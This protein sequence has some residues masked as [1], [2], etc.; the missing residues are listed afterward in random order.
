MSLTSV[1]L[2][3]NSSE[4]IGWQFHRLA[5][6][7]ALIVGDAFVV[8]VSFVLAYVMRFL[9]NLPFF[10]EGAMQSEFYTLLIMML[11]PSWIALFAVYH[12]YDDK[13][14]FNGTQEYQ[15]ITNATSMGMLIVVLL[16]FFWDNL[17]VARG[18]LLLSWFLSLS[19]MTLWRF[20]VR[21]FVYWL[22][23][24]G[25]LH[26]RVL[27]IGATE[28]GRAIAEQLLAEQ[29]A[30]AT[31]V[32]FIDNTLPVG[33]DVI[34]GKVKVLGTTGDFTELIQHNNI[35]TIIIADTNLIREQ[36]ITI[37]GAMDVLS[38]L[39][40]MLAPGLFDLLTIG[41]QVREQ[42]A[43]PLLSLNKT[44]ITGL[45]A[46]GK[47]IV[48]VV[49]AL[50]GLMLLSPL[51][52]CVAIA[53]KLDSPGPIIYRRRVIGVGYREFSAF[54]FRTMYIDGDRR[55]TPE[56]RAE[57]AQKGKLI[58]DPRITRVGKWLRRTSIDELPQLINV[59]LG[60]MS[61]VGPRMITASEMH[62]FG[63][64]QHNLLMVRPGLTGLW[65][66]S[67]RSNLG[68]ADRVRLDMHYIRNYSIW[69]DL[70]IIYRTVPVL[71]KGEGAY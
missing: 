30:G 2:K 46:I 35:E 59:L 23:K 68:Y 53:I 14:L 20:S 41:V 3:A 62:H 36:L 66:I 57:L 19:L 37:N 71:L 34:H 67:G 27:I 44:R 12:L 15:H 1:E 64:W 39:E 28:E 29:R 69:L 51:L 45:H 6:I 65:Q 22:R 60:Q 8:T 56:Q 42:G 49:G 9:T 40:I 58:D 21:R 32:G 38:R 13:L 10:N 70:F 18:W 54:K 43:V 4:R 24:H 50:V 17:V 16:T 48:D 55:L 31:I 33:S 11:V 47:K 61:L 52:I 7:G 63:R 25:H 5:L 26:K